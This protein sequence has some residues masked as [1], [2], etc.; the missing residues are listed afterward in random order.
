M[1]IVRLVTTL[2]PYLPFLLGLGSKPS[3]KES[4]KLVQKAVQEIWNKLYSQVNATPAALDAA[5]DVAQNPHNTDSAQV[6]GNQLEKILDAPENVSLKEEISEI[7]DHINT[8]LVE[9]GEFTTDA[10]GSTLGLLI[11]NGKV[12]MNLGTRL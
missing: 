1:N 5:K 8:K 11:D 7:L 9:T 2:T 4:E 12:D 6:L 10:T 3:K